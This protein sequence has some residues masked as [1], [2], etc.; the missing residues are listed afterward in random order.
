MITLG[1]KTTMISYHIIRI[2][3]CCDW[4]SNTVLV[5]S[6]DRF[7][8]LLALI[9]SRHNLDRTTLDPKM[10]KTEYSN[11]ECDIQKGIEMRV[12]P[13]SSLIDI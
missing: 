2:D 3:S 10:E 12:P 1:T 9:Q 11:K 7:E 6:K 13:V 5:Q 8:H 4:L